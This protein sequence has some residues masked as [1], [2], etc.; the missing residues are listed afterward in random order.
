MRILKLV[1]ENFKRLQVVRIDPEKGLTIVG[2]RNA[3]GKSSTLDA[4]MAALGGK[5]HTPA[6]AVRKGQAR[7]KVVLDLGDD[8]EL[9]DIRVTRTFTP[10]GGGTIIIEG[11]DG[12]RYPSPQAMLD[13]LIGRLSYDPLAFE[14]MKDDEQAE[15]L[16]ALVGLDTSDLD[17]EHERTYNLRT[18]HNRTVKQLEGQLAGLDPQPGVPAEEVSIADLTA[19]LSEAQASRAAFDEGKRAYQDALTAQASAVAAADATRAEIARLQAVLEQQVEAI[20]KQD[21]AVDAA[22]T[23]G[24]TL[25]AALVDTAPILDAIK[26]ADAINAKVRQNLARA[27]VETQL[28][29]ELEASK[30]LTDKLAAIEQQREAR[31][32]AAQFPI[33]G[34]AIDG[35]TVLFDG[36]PFRQAS[37]A[38]RLRVSA[39]I[40]FALNP[41]LKLLLIREGSALDSASLQLLAELAE[42]MDGQILLEKVAESAEGVSVLIE[43]GAVM[44]SAVSA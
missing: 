16:R 40:G 36:V 1:A 19:Q 34:L 18:E 32:A 43:D 22:K 14:R 26:N 13:K 41:K 15:T 37:Q 21:A 27:K 31:I 33:P 17:A 10:D 35:T 9:A 5:K 42:E 3:Q 24:V 12:S 8:P 28:A 39:A 20:A 29:Q 30:I 11:T 2:G 38:Q 6:M 7:A 44:A 23:A 25:R 4:V